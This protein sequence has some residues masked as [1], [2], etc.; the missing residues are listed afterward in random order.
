MVAKVALTNSDMI[1]IN[2]KIKG[3]SMGNCIFFYIEAVV[4]YMNVQNQFNFCAE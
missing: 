3:L 2:K 4:D 1:M